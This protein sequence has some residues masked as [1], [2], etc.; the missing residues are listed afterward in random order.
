M[1]DDFRVQIYCSPADS[2]KWKFERKYIKSG[3]NIVEDGNPGDLVIAIMGPTGVGK[4]TFINTLLDDGV[5]QIG[6]G[7]ISCTE[8]LQ[9]VIV[10]LPDRPRLV[11]LDTPGFDDTYIDDAE[12]LRRISVWLAKS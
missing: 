2:R 1:L 11:I 6:H 9:H 12:I 10:P 5:M 8:H 4:S 7:L 3:D